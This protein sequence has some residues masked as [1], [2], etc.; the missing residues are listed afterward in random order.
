[1]LHTV[2]GYYHSDGYISHFVSLVSPSLKN[3]TQIMPT[4]SSETFMTQIFDTLKNSITTAELSDA[5]V[6]LLGALFEVND[7]QSGNVIAKQGVADSD[8]LYILVL[9]HI[10]VRTQS[11]E[12]VLT[13]QMNEPGD[14]ANIISFVGGRTTEIHTLI[15]VVGATRLLS[16]SRTR[17]EGL[18]FSHPSVMYRFTRGIVRHMHRI[19]RDKNSDLRSQISQ[20]SAFDIEWQTE[21]RPISIVERANLPKQNAGITEAAMG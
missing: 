10:E 6:N 17:F 20:V 14:L 3:F 19:L 15:H 16:L 12:G 18:I 11:T 4:I 1:V 2:F 7:Y 8:N 9:G 13:I 21:S 5:E